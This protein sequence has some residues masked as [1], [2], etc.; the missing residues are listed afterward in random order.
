MDRG[1]KPPSGAPELG[2]VSDHFAAA[3]PAAGSQSREVQAHL[4]HSVQFVIAPQEVRGM[5]RISDR[6]VLGRTGSSAR[7]AK[8]P[9]F[10]IVC[11][12]FAINQNLLL[13]GNRTDAGIQAGVVRL[14]ANL[15]SE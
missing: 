13:K 11:L 10:G 4:E 14:G 12:I 2:F 6:G 15:L 5:H 1:E 7:R 8:R 3:L 9:G